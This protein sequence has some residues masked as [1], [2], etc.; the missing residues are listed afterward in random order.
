MYPKMTQLY[1]KR[2]T[3]NIEMRL[4]IYKYRDMYSAMRNILK[5]YEGTI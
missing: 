2:R 4:Y 1:W 5:D 3:E